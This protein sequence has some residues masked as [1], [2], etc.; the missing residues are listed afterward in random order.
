MNSAAYQC[1]G[2][3]VSADVF[4]Q[5]AC[6][7]QRSVVV[8]ACAGAGKTWM[9]VSRMIRALLQ[10]SRPQE[11]L[12]ITF[13]RKAAS[14]MRDRLMQWL[15][16]WRTNQASDE[17]RIHMLCERG[18]SRPDAEKAQ[19]ALGEL[20]ESILRS[21]RSVEIRTFHAWF[22][23]L[24][25][26]APLE[27]LD[28]LQL[29]PNMQLLE[30]TDPH[31]D[32]I[33][34]RFYSKLVHDEPLKADFEA[35]MRLR[36]KFST[37]EWLKTSLAKRIE[38]EWAAKKGVLQTSVPQILGT[39]PKTSDPY[40][41]I[42]ESVFQEPLKEILEHLRQKPTKKSQN[43][44]AA[45][46]EALQQPQAREIFQ[47]IEKLWSK[48][49]F[50]SELSEF[51]AAEKLRKLI[52]D[53]KLADQQL[54]NHK[55]HQRMARLSLALIQIYLAYYLEKGFADFH[56]LEQCELTLFRESYSAAW[57]QERLD[58]RI[59]HVLIDEFQDTSPLQWQ[60]LH[61]WLSGYAGSGGGFSGKIPP[62]VFIVG[63]PKQSIYRF[64]GAEPR[65]FEAAKAYLQEGLGGAFL[66]CDHTR[67]NA[68]QV[69]EAVNHV[70]DTAQVA[71]EFHGFR[72]HTTELPLLNPSSSSPWPAS[73]WAL[74]MVTIQPEADLSAPKAAP[75]EALETHPARPSLFDWRD[76][77]TTPRQEERI[78]RR[79]QEAQQLARMVAAVLAHPAKHPRSERALS[80]GD[81]YVLARKRESLHILGHELHALGIPFAAPE[82]MTLM[83]A[84]EV[85]DVVAL[86][87]FLA[88][89]QHDLALARALK[90][91]IFSASDADLVHIAQQVKSLYRPTQ[92]AS[93]FIG[94]VSWWAALDSVSET[95]LSP[96][97]QRARAHLR[98][99][100][101]LVPK[102]T[103]HDL[104]D[105]I[106]HQGDIL[107][108]MLAATPPAQSML[109]QN[110]LTAL[111][112]QSLLLNGARYTTLYQLVRTLKRQAVPLLPSTSA[113]AVQLLT[114]HGAK[115]LEAEVVFLMD[116]HPADQGSKYAS[117]LIDWPVNSDA[118]HT[119]AFIYSEKNCPPSLWPLM[120]QE[121]LARHR[122][123]LNGLYVAMTRAKE[124]LVM[125]AHERKKASSPEAHTW[126]QRLSPLATLSQTVSSEALPTGP[127]DAPR[128]VWALPTLQPEAA[129]PAL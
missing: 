81:I 106:F 50:Q 80:P 9:L 83:D 59:R 102:L 48:K 120:E 56:D 29:S 95:D 3:D 86:L 22:S 58:T 129:D 6:N 88:S 74:P 105:Q 24:F 62:S 111:L 52:E 36:G 76:S 12:A 119:C 11:I 77:L 125:S 89:P 107:E 100:R 115:G 37:L 94:K 23:Q 61:A 25:R 13:T 38:I 69:L 1:D 65:V 10:G 101:S 108:R 128:R 15:S 18:M 49:T 55:E 117:L 118:P 124:C 96:A 31:L 63:D 60:A 20:H 46:E 70:F 33:F 121:K 5:T 127:A 40:A 82:S 4:Y 103:P 2:Q 54:E 26:G 51:S 68:P 112:G 7:P 64:R 99:W 19:A 90:S 27:M 41:A 43:I 98:A 109:A 30:K 44:S 116:T 87:D 32:D 42:D 104:L 84:P 114:V 85:Q 39:W 57:M 75:E 66:A 93:P 79:Q 91:P 78:D 97:L 14:E 45:I 126:W 113:D 47:A 8:E 28:E 17:T 35:Q 34:H 92:G 72:R 21:G 73:L 123:E 67:R 53:I 122:E 16:D 71:G 110:A